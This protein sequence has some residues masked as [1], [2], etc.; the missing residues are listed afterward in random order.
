MTF[1]ALAVLAA[2]AGH[3][4]PQDEAA[5][6][7]GLAEAL[8][9]HERREVRVILSG[10]PDG[11]GRLDADDDGFVTR[12]EFSA[13]LSTAFDRLDTDGDGRL[14]AG[15]LAAGGPRGTGPMILRHGGAGDDVMLRHGPGGPDDDRRVFMFRS[16]GREG[17][18]GEHGPGERRIEIRRMGGPDGDASLDT[19]DDGKVSEEEFL[20]P[21]REAFQRLDD[22]RDGALDTEER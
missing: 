20:A 8:D 1:A 7:A 3:A 15:E 4:T 21:M 13:P 19:D 11:P 16:G 10:G 22:D 9:R 6:R 12:E 14:N 18:P 2:L 5:L 17:G